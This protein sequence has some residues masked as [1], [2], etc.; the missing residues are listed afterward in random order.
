MMISNEYDQEKVSNRHA[1]CK[2]I[3]ADKSYNEVEA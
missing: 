1:V 3:I 2:Q